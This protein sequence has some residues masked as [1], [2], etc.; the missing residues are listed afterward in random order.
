MVLRCKDFITFLR[1][2]K[3]T[4]LNGNYLF[5][6]QIVYAYW[7][8]TTGFIVNKPLG[9]EVSPHVTSVILIDWGV[10]RKCV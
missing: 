9:E 6:V 3:I 5:H 1:K 4:F 8:K 10:G 2:V 7:Y